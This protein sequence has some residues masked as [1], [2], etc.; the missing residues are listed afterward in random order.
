VFFSFDFQIIKSTV[1]KMLLMILL[2]VS[3]HSSTI[4]FFICIRPFFVY[5][6]IILSKDSKAR[7]TF[8]IWTIL[9]EH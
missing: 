3:Y 2:Y 7:Y 4:H 5:R 1:M 6:N 9:K 8:F